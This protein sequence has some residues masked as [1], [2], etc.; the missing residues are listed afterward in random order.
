MSLSCSCDFDEPPKVFSQRIVKAKKPHKC[1]ECRK[2]IK[3]GD[4]Y[5]YTFGVWGGDAAA[6]KTCEPCA[7]LR[8][9]LQDAG[10]CMYFGGLKSAHEEY[11]SEYEPPAMKAKGTD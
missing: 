10:F 3:P 4:T 6:Y 2:E 11:L 7:D 1:C 9:S 5:E 8:E